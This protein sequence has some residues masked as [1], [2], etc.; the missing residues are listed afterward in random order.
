[1]PP[2]AEALAAIS[3]GTLAAGH[4]GGIATGPAQL[5]D[6]FVTL[7]EIHYP[8]VVRALELGGASRPDA[9][10]VAQ[11]AFART[12]SHWRRVRR[13]TNPAGYLFTVAFRL[14]RR[15]RAVTLVLDDGGG[16]VAGAL[17]APSGLAGDMAGLAVA[18]ADLATALRA[19]PSGRRAC[20]VL[21]IVAGASPRDAG[22]AL[23]I[24]ESTVRKQLERARVELRSALG[25]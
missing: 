15:R 7:Y 14:A 3:P 21:C 10:D 19:M 25:D 1:M 20:A 4:T 24:A 17:A 12:L 13:G 9:E 23:G 5:H 6:D 11:E 18:R 8:R 2:A 22:R 16:A